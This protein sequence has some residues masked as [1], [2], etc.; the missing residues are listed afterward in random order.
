VKPRVSTLGS[1]KHG[2]CG[3]SKPGRKDPLVTLKKGKVRGVPKSERKKA[4]NE[5]GTGGRR[6]AGVATG[7]QQIDVGGSIQRKHT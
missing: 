1:L 5:G 7:S 2:K 4:L 6:N 3:R